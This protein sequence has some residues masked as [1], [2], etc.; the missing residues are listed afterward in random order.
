ML[1]ALNLSKTV[2]LYVLV[3]KITN[4]GFS[5]KA[6]D[7]LFSSEI[8]NGLLP[9]SQLITQLQTQRTNSMNQSPSSEIDS[10]RQSKNPPHFIKPE[11]LS[12][13]SK[14]PAVCLLPQPA[15]SSQ[16]AE[17][18]YFLKI[19]LPYMSR[20]LTGYLLLWFPQQ[21]LAGISPLRVTCPAL[22]IRLAINISDKNCCPPGSDVAQSRRIF[23]DFRRNRL[24]PSSG[25][26]GSRF[27][28]NIYQTAQRHV[29]VLRILDLYTFHNNTIL[30]RQPHRTTS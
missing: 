10:S 21:N 13:L 8:I 7:Y 3:A 22:L 6:R 20:S 29:T 30:S 9:R 19:I 4:I 17:P 12:P 18:S 5:Y 2:R 24:H 14:K 27:R 15:Q 11:G 23:P 16:C 26:K 1:I 28:N 25:Q